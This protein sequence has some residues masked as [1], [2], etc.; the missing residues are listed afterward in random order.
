MIAVIGYSK[1]FP[2]SIPALVSGITGTPM[3]NQIGIMLVIVVSILGFS[4]TLVWRKY[5]NQT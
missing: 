2:W 1:F 4:V 3:L 5:A